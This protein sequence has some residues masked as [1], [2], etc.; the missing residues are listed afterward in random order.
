MGNRQEWAEA[1]D[2]LVKDMVALGF[3]EEFGIII[4]K[5][6]ES[7]RA[8]RRM[9]AYLCQVK[10]QN[11][12]LIVDEMLSIRSEVDAWK[13][14]KASEEANAAYNEMLNYGLGTEEESEDA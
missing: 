11:E 8:M 12:I 6:L 3:P 2:A 4:A 7:P 10:P 13:D 14:K 5:H 1:R 9:S